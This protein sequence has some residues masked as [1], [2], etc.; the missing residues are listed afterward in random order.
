MMRTSQQ[1][2]SGRTTILF[3]VTVS[4]CSLCYWKMRCLRM[5]TTQIDSRQYLTTLVGRDNRR[6]YMHGVRNRKPVAVTESNSVEQHISTTLPSSTA[7]SDAVYKDTKSSHNIVTPSSTQIPF[8]HRA[9]TDTEDVFSHPRVLVVAP[10]TPS[11]QSSVQIKTVAF[12]GLVK[13]AARVLQQ[14]VS[15]LRGIACMP[16]VQASLYVVEG[17]SIDATRTMLEAF[18]HRAYDSPRAAK[19]TV[20]C[21]DNSYAFH[22]FHVLDQPVSFS[23]FSAEYKSNST[24]IGT[25]NHNTRVDNAKVESG[26]LNPGE[27]FE[28]LDKRVLF[29]QVLRNFQRDWMAKTHEKSPFDAVVLVDFDLE[30]FPSAASVR[31]AMASVAH[32]HQDSLRFVHLVKLRTSCGCGQA[33][34]TTT[35]LQ[36]CCS[37]EHSRI[38]MGRI[39]RRRTS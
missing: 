3:V 17:G 35:V 6:I 9:A 7:A 27:T 14:R 15:D 31:A 20:F 5:V 33:R 11:M 23:N 18:R 38:T 2:V 16:D 39:P 8:S 24:S 36:P 34:R 19:K 28:G 25:S 1:C 29:M 13:D 21:K 10:T 30:K 32:L 26:H 4:V 22:E 37:M 12:F